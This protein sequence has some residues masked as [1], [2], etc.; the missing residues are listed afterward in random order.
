M[1]K[2]LENLSQLKQEIAPYTP[3]IIAVTKYYDES[4]VIEAYEAGLRDFGE[5]RVQDAIAKFSKLPDEIRQN[6]TFHLIGHLQTNKVK[7]AVGEFDYIHSVDSLKLAEAISETAKAKGIVQKIFLQINNAGEEQK[8]GL[9]P[10]ELFRD[11]KNIISLKNLEITGLMT[12][13][14]L[15]D[16]EKELR[17]LFQEI[18]QIKDKIKTEFGYNLREISMGMSN[19]FRI[20]IEE[21]STIIRIGRKLFN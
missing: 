6:S 18:I 20:A 3:K 4:K 15:I 7:K 9:S 14:P 1:N 5:N 11:F 8:S 13:A 12:I 10:Q 16:D 2:V 21:G 17:R 19:D